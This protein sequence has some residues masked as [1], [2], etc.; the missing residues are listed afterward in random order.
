MT[1]IEWIELGR[2]V[3]ACDGYKPKRGMAGWSYTPDTLLQFIKHYGADVREVAEPRCLWDGRGYDVPFTP[4]LRDPGTLGHCLAMMRKALMRPGDI[5]GFIPRTMPTV[6]SAVGVDA[7]CAWYVEH[8]RHEDGASRWH[9]GATTEAKAIV[10][11]WES[12]P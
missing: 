8:A 11:A 4:D 5:G 1:D 6:G 12:A 3:M 9:K 2:R 10:N 7:E